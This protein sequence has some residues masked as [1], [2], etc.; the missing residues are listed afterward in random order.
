MTAPAIRPLRREDLEKIRHLVAEAAPQL[1]LVRADLEA[2][3]IDDPDGADDLRPVL[4][5]SG[6]IA[7][8]GCAVVRPSAAGDDPGAPHPRREPVGHVKIVAVDRGHRRRGLGRRLLD[9]L[10]MAMASR[11][12]RR[13]LL[14]GAAPVYLQPGVPAAAAGAISFFESRGY[15]RTET[16]ASLHTDLAHLDLDAPGE[17]MRLRAEGIEIE[18]ADPSRLRGILEA[19]EEEFSSA[20]AREA[21]RAAAGPAAAL[22]VAWSGDRLAGFCAAA[23]W[24][25][26]VLGPVGTAAPFERRGIGTA[27]ARRCLRDLRGAGEKDA[28]AAW[29]GPRG[30]Y[31]RLAPGWREIEYAAMEKAI[32]GS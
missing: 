20:W 32:S 19:I 1:H 5:I 13:A 2:N 6:R 30:F 17:E 26:N 18:R 16:R 22:H 15:R 9:A 28:I 8:L 27:L 25:R 31:L 7:A 29:I 12:A 23:T 11:G 3:L 10:E 21:E 4:E 24:A 14:D